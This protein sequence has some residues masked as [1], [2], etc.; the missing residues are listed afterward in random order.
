MIGTNP[1]WAGIPSPA[2]LIP[3]QARV[4][5]RLWVLLLEQIMQG[6]LLLV[7][8]VIVWVA[9]T[10]LK[11]SKVFPFNCSQIFLSC[12]SS[13]NYSFISVSPVLKSVNTPPD[14]SRKTEK[15]L[16]SKI[17]FF[18]FLG[19]CADNTSGLC[20]IR[21]LQSKCVIYRRIKKVDS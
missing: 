21:T 5:Q 20:K 13:G 16:P 12:F 6:H 1:M 4:I 2:V 14:P 7:M 11:I 10:V 15:P 19:F 18:N 3:R 8:I 17:S 9:L